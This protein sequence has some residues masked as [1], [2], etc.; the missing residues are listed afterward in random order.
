MFSNG[1]RY[2]GEYRQLPG[3]ITVRSGFG[4]HLSADGTIYMGIWDNDKMN[5]SGRLQF[6]SGAV[7]EGEFVN[8]CF[9]GKGQYTWP[10]GSHFDGMFDNNRMFSY[11]QFTDTE[12]QIW[13]GGFFGTRAPGLRYK[14]QM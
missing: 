2:D 4:I 11:G 14:L 5:G 3:G 12:G 13:Y 1:D 8:N 7:Y 10:N 6:S 9:N